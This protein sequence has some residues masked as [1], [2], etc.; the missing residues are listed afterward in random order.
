VRVWDVTTRNTVVTYRGHSGAV[1]AV[2]WSPDSSQLAS[3]GSDGTVQVWEATTGRSLY[4]FS[5]YCVPGPNALVPSFEAKF[6]RM[7][8]AGNDRFE[9][10][11]MR[12]TGEWVELYTDLTLDECLAAIREE[13]YFAIG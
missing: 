6:A 11:F 2:T 9:L 5:T 7:R 12:Y 8:Y 1:N 13:P 10:S 3:G 4:F